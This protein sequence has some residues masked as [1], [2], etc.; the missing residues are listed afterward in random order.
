MNQNK[1]KI[2]WAVS[3]GEAGMV[4]QVMGLAEATG[5][6]VQQKSIRLRAPWSWLPGHLTP[7]ALKGLSADADILIPPWPDLMITCG[8]RS[9][10]ASIAVRRL[11]AGKTFTVHVQNPLV[12]NRYLDLVLPPHHDGL[13]GTNVHPTLASIHRITSEK[14]SQEA[15]RMASYFADLPRPLVC[16]VIGGNSGAHKLTR[17]ATEKLADRLLFLS[18][19]KGVGFVVTTSRRTGEENAAILK[20]KLAG[21]NCVVWSGEGENPYFAMLGLADY[22]LVTS[23]SA[24][25]VSEACATGKP[26]HIIDLE[27]GNQRFTKFHE[28]L[29]NKGITRPFTGQLK[30]W[31]YPPLTCTQDAAKL[32]LEKMKARES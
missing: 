23:D 24:S 10:A 12:P 6:T 9:V 28:G 31:T 20:N 29:R 1:N 2:C 26:V 11:S 17:L 14:L 25:M 18:K 7:L 13:T 22:I 19:N 4:S 16:V 21:P 32:V 8:R 5:L 27:G 3:T 30:D 15:D